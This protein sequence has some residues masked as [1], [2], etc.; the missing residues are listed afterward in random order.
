MIYVLHGEDTFSSNEF[1]RR[2]LEA[3]GPPDLRDSN[4]ASFEA[5]AFT[6]ER[7]GAAA[8][9]MP[10]LAERRL[11]VVRGLM[12][13]AEGQGR[14]RRGQDRA[15]GV[16]AGLADLLRQ[17][18]PTTDAVFLEGKLTASNPVLAAVKELGPDL[19]QAREFPP[20]RGDELGRWIV[21]RAELKGAEIEGRA[22]A[23]LADM[24]GPNLWAM[25][26]EIEKLSLYCDERPIGPDDVQAL[27]TGAKEANVFR[28]VDAIMARRAD[29]ALAEMRTL[30][31]TGAAGPY[32]LSMVARQ[33]RMIAVAQELIAQGTPQQE[34]GP[35]LGTGSAFV[36]RKTAEQAR[37]FSPDAVRRLYRL[38]VETDVAIKTGA[39]EELALTE[40]LTRAAGLPAPA[41]GGG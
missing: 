29:A 5:G 2:L 22:V 36:V 33:A 13:A 34:W 27:V 14:G 26:S 38:L 28:L 23:M 18:P 12:G 16:Q 39:A 25:D 21:D 10:F 20:L 30:L 32:L 6:I 3:V 8:M 15:A 31:D 40:M 35:R 19:V 41:R 17:L 37:R 7:F 4:A 1:L 24:V 9:A 11:V